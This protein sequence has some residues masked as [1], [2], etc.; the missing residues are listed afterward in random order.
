METDKELVDKIK[1]EIS[2]YGAG[3]VMPYMLEQFDLTIDELCEEQG[4]DRDP[5]KHYLNLWR[6]FPK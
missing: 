2:K 5:H 4:W 6:V 3:F 1:A